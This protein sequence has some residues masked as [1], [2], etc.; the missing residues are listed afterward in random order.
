MPFPEN[1]S[2]AIT[3]EEF[4]QTTPNL[5]EHMR[6]NLLNEDGICEDPLYPYTHTCMHSMLE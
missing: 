1:F 2:K 3:L 5:L 6:H 4:D